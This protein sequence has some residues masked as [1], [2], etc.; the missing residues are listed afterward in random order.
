[1]PLRVE[2]G[3]D[4][5]LDAFGSLLSGARLDSVLCHRPHKPL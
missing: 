1:M 5:T 3:D 2:Y 4:H